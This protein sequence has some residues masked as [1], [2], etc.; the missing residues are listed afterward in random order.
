MTATF[1]NAFYEPFLHDQN[2]PEYTFV[3][4]PPPPVECVGIVQ[5]AGVQIRVM[6]Q[7]GRD[8]RHVPAGVEYPK[9]GLLEI[10][11]VKGVW[12]DQL[13]TVPCHVAGMRA[14]SYWKRN[15]LPTVQ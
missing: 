3:P 7:L 10:D 2:K 1:I 14:L 9:G 12:Y 8:K 13:Q 4:P 6:W 5:P 15:L 11:P